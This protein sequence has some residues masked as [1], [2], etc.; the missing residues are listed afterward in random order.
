MYRSRKRG[1]YSAPCSSSQSAWRR[2][3]SAIDFRPRLVIAAASLIVR[4]AADFS[5]SV[6]RACFAIF[7]TSRGWRDTP[8]RPNHRPVTQRT[9]R[10]ISRSEKI[11]TDPPPTIPAKIAREVQ[12]RRDRDSV[13][14]WPLPFARA[15]NRPGRG[16]ALR[17]DRP[18]LQPVMA[19]VRRTIRMARY[20]HRDRIGA[21]PH[22]QAH[23]RQ[24]GHL[25]ERSALPRSR[26]RRPAGCRR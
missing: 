19:C 18:A 6:S 16:L 7:V 20:V 5:G 11:P 21:I 22:V 26:S 14:P 25:S 1:P 8:H 15:R 12:E 9:A 23:Q 13:L 17:S 4:T 2:S 10:P 3:Q 24:M